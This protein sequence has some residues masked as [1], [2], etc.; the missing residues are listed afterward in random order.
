M[1][2]IIAILQD[3]SY[4][5][6]A[7]QLAISVIPLEF[8]TIGRNFVREEAMADRSNTGCRLPLFSA[9][10]EPTTI[11]PRHIQVWMNPL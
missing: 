4:N 7:A 11:H 3:M 8:T 1:P 5:I 9:Y 10:G 6:T 2:S